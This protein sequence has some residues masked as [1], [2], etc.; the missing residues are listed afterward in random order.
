MKSETNAMQWVCEGESTFRPSDWA[1]RLAGMDAAFGA[2]QRL[3]YSP[4]LRPA[5]RDGK[6]CLCMDPAI[7]Q[8]R[9]ALYQTIIAFA[10]QH[11]LKLFAPQA[12]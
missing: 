4:Y 1:V 8:Q 7:A 3:R 6:H 5:N 9:P 2:D 10:R 12:A 11:G